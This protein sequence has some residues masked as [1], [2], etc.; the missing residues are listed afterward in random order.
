[1][2]AFN[3]TRRDGLFSLQKTA[4]RLCYLITKFEPIIRQLYPNNALL[5]AALAAAMAACQELE[6]QV[7]L[8][9]TP[10]E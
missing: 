7:S 1:M 6:K 2:T 8:E 10:G 4:R 5:L 9:I 3:I